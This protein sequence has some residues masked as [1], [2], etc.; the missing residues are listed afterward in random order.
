MNK[1]HYITAIVIV[2]TIALSIYYV[3]FRE[4]EIEDRLHKSRYILQ[5][6]IRN[7]ELDRFPARLQLDFDRLRRDLATIEISK[8][9]SAELDFD[10]THPPYFD[11]KNLYLVTVDKVAVY[12]KN[13]LERI[14][15][16]QA[17]HPIANFTLIDGNNLLIVD[18]SGQIYSLNR[19][20][21][22]QNWT[23]IH[24][25][26]LYES[27]YSPLK[28]MQIT[29]NEDKRLITSII[30]IPLKDEM[31]IKDPI[32]GEVLYTLDFDEDIY[33]ISEYDPIDNAIYV[34]YGNKI[35]KIILEKK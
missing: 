14:W 35:G 3:F 34:S 4:N 10:L 8:I 25:N 26:H 16:V 27:I 17:D 33:H 23:S 1:K 30:I 22:E 28:P 21:G 19:N 15:I 13:T 9:W 7:I 29:N 20:T 12:D 18:N 2:I 24:Q 32:S 31:Q 5:E 6:R 11:L